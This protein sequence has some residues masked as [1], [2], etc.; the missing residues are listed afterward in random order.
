[1]TCFSL[2]K[3]KKVGDTRRTS[4]AVSHLSTTRAFY[5]LVT[6]FEWDRTHSIEDDRWQMLIS[7]KKM[8]RRLVVQAQTHLLELHHP[9]LSNQCVQIFILASHGMH[10][11]RGP[12]SPKLA[13][14]WTVVTDHNIASPSV[15][16]SGF[17]RPLRSRCIN[18][19]SIRGALYTICGTNIICGISI[20]FHS[21]WAY[22]N[23]VDQVVES[24]KTDFL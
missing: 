2:R 3:C 13:I 22:E 20:H 23:N 6:E 15:I 10:H 11:T 7:L 1:M 24:Q 8:L 5:S 18:L 21:T 12:A 16:S 4:Q 9:V 17:G 14:L 19:V